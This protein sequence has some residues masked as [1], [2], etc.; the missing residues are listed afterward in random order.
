MIKLNY[1]RWLREHPEHQQTKR[2]LQLINLVKSLSKELT[3]LGIVRSDWEDDR[4]VLG[5]FPIEN[6]GETLF[7][8]LAS[9]RSLLPS[10]ANHRIAMIFL[11][12]SASL[13]VQR[14]NQVGG[15]NLDIE[16]IAPT[17]FE[18]RVPQIQ[19]PFPIKSQTETK[20]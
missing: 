2:F 14:S 7:K 20:S 17:D 18:N 16:P 4:P 15:F 3:P 8:T 10:L 6:P 1:V 19:T 13:W 11:Q 9:W 5:A 12:F